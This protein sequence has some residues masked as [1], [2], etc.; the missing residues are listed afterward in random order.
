MP[1]RSTLLNRCPSRRFPSSG[2]P[3]QLSVE[4][5]PPF[6]VVKG[7]PFDLAKYKEEAST[8][9]LAICWRD[10]ARR[11]IPVYREVLYCLA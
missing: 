9:L 5:Y 6:P 2:H 1:C 10:Q 3:F 4:S 8:I 11:L 7:K